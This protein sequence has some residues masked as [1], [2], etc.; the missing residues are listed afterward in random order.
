MKTTLSIF[1]I[2]LTAACGGSGGSMAN[3]PSDTSGSSAAVTASI[4]AIDVATDRTFAGMLN[5]VRAVNGSDPLSYNNLL[6]QAAQG[7]AQDMLDQNYFSHT[8]L[9]GRTLGDRVTAT[10]YSWRALGENIA[11]GQSDEE[12]VLKAWVNSPGHQSNNISPNNSIL[13]INIT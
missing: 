7:H 1:A 12:A 4:T 13:L 10:D 9:D 2:C 3:M 5:D 8:S 6:G 11:Y